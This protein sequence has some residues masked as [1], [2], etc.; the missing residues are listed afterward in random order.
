MSARRPPAPPPG[1]ILPKCMEDA[2]AAGEMKRPRPEQANKGLALER[3]LNDAHAAYRA[4]GV[5]VAKFPTPTRRV[6]T[7]TGIVWVQTG[8]PVVDFIGAIASGT[9]IVL[10]AKS[11]SEPR[12]SLGMLTDEQ[13]TFLRDWPGFKLVIVEFS[14]PA[15]RSVWA[16]PSLVVERDRRRGV[17]SYQHPEM[18]TTR[19]TGPSIDDVGVKLFGVDWLPALAVGKEWR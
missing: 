7:K 19:T 6:K 8:A 18:V 5:V 14:T 17:K 15:I 13:Q 11:T 2:I 12:W 9:G 4:R 16:L 10:E 1:M 3:A